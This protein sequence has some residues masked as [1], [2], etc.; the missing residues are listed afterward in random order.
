[1]KTKQQQ[2]TFEKG[3]TN[4]PS[5]LICSDNTMQE[6]V[7]LTYR[8]GEHHVIQQPKQVIEF[9]PVPTYAQ[10]YEYAKKTKISRD[11]LFV[12]KYNGQE[13]YIVWQYTEWD[14]G[15]VNTD[16]RW[17]TVDNNG[18]YVPATD[19]T[20]SAGTYVGDLEELELDTDRILFADPNHTATVT[21]IG[22]TLIFTTDEGLK[23]AIWKGDYYEVFDNLPE[24]QFFSRLDSNLTM[25]SHLSREGIISDNLTV[26]LNKEKAYEDLV[27]G[28]L[29]ENK[30]KIARDRGFAEPFFAM[31]ALEM[32]DGSYTLMTAPIFMPA[33]VQ[34]HSISILRYMTAAA[35]NF[36]GDLLDMF[37][38]YSYMYF[39][40]RTDY[41]EFA[42]IVKDVVIFISDGVSLYDTNGVYDFDSASAVHVSTDLAADGVRY[43]AQYTQGAYTAFTF[44]DITPN[45]YNAN[46]ALRR[47]L[48]HRSQSDINRDIEQSSVFY[49]LCSIGIKRS[50]GF[51]NSKIDPSTLENL[52]TQT[53]LKYSDYFSHCQLSAEMTYVYN[54]RLNLAGIH[55][56][57]YDGFDFFV[58]W[59]HPNANPAQDPDANLNHYVAFVRIDTDSGEKVV[60][61]EYD[62]RQKQGLWFYYPDSRAKWATIYNTTQSNLRVLDAELKEHPSLNG[63]YYFDGMPSGDFVEGSHVGAITDDT[64]PITTTPSTEPEYL[65]NQI[66]TSEVNNPFVF[67]AEGYNTVGTGEIIGMAAL[68]Q[69]L[70]QGQFGQYP[71]LVFTDE[72]IW[73]MSLDNTGLYKSIHPMSR[74]VAL[75][76]NPCITQTDN[77]VFFVSEKGL[78]VVAGNQVQ[79]VSP[80]LSGKA[81]V[82]TSS[83]VGAINYHDFFAGCKIAYDYRDSLLWMINKSVVSQKALVYAIKSGTFSYADLPDEIKIVVNDYPD[84]LIQDEIEGNVYSLMN[85]P[86]INSNEAKAVNYEAHIITRPLKLENALALKSIMQI[87]HIMETENG[88]PLSFR[89]FASNDTKHWTELTSL[90]GTPWKFYRFY[91]DFSKRVE[92]TTVGTLKTADTFAGSVLITQERRTNRLR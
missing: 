43:G 70:S 83:L 71:L 2:L 15:T 41:S 17:G 75:K 11:L 12:H 45:G 3:I 9:P 39:E 36:Y 50:S 18:N 51:V 10:D 52:T 74:E 22:K 84:Y 16:I 13:R 47:P 67:L 6:C 82:P 29:A 78:M 23:Y 79:C 48:K 62:G 73:A 53:Q 27:L 64:I 65:P 88:N 59:S 58:T 92:D 69:A 77:A 34:E 60:K 4:V 80:Q 30:K 91:Y 49:K 89:I 90:R 28:L 8:D 66:A 72:G 25:Q 54:A 63:S 31:A 85:R 24:L 42:D 21:A 87:K 14:T 46:S 26:V 61:K 56:G 5:D 57:F 55:R 7:N 1:M 19:E 38:C 81:T 33:S 86:N 40:Q 20:S 76:S 35:D 44:A 37:T 68:T 32:Y